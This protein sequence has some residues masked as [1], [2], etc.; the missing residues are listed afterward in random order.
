MALTDQEIGHHWRIANLEDDSWMPQIHERFARAI[1]SAAAAPLLARIAALTAQVEQAAQPVAQWQKM[2]PLRTNGRWENTDEFDAKW[3]RDN[4]QGWEI[5]PLYTAPPKAVPL[6]NQDVVGYHYSKMN[7][8]GQVVWHVDYAVH[9]DAIEWF[10]L[11]H[12]SKG[13]TPAT[14]EKG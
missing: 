8:F 7:P 1:E 9:T 14:V 4:S 13:I 5:R 2:H 3:W 10:P 12:G 6:T 11:V